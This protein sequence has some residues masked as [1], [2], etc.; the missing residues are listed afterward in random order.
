MKSLYLIFAALAFGLLTGC[1][2][3]HEGDRYLLQEHHVSPSLYAR[4]L[5]GEPLSL[6]DVI[7]LSQR[8]VPPDFIVH[9]LWTSYAV[10]H[11][12]ST[13]I[14]NLRKAGVSKQV[15]DYMLASGPMYAPRPYSYY[16]APG[17]YAPYPY[18]PYGYGYPAVSFGVGYGGWY[19]GGYG[20]HGH[21]WH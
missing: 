5:H 14:S 8:Q 6:S 9:Y 2:T 7:E 15:I 19:G 16:G 18:Y 11:L 4:M 3:L 21:Y 13:D 1:A 10:Y 17:Y 12:S 20:C